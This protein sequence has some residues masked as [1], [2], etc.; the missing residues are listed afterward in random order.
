MGTL[1]TDA[2]RLKFEDQFIPDGVAWR[3]CNKKENPFEITPDRLLLEGEY[4]IYTSFFKATG[5]RLPFDPLLVDFRRET[6]FHID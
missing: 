1:K 2:K 5:L 3:E 4:P 6:R